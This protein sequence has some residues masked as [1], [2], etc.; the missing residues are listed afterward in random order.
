MG[1]VIKIYG[2]VIFGCIG[3]FLLLNLNTRIFLEDDIFETTRTTQL[4]A[5]QDNLNLGDLFVNGKYSIQ[6]TQ[7]ME[8]WIQKFNENK[9]NKFYYKLDFIGIHE[10]P[11]AIAIRV[12]GYSSLNMSE[13]DLEL[14]YTN[15]VLIEERGNG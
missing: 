6:A 12:R 4:S 1:G 15:V 9:N 7:T 5:I 2:I 11:P 14:D 13:D 10:T 3:L 8:N